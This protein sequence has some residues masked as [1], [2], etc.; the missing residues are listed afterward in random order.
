MRFVGRG[1]GSSPGTP[2]TGG[3]RSH[4]RLPS[5][6]KGKVRERGVLFRG[7]RSAGSVGDDRPGSAI[8]ATIP[9]FSPCGT[10]EQEQELVVELW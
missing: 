5:R 3:A 7:D 6:R 8:T 9:F 4:T 1:L 2:G 10:V